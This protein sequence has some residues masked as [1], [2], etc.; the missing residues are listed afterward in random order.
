M[1][2]YIVKFQED[3]ISLARVAVSQWL[4]APPI[5]FTQA[6]LSIILWHNASLLNVRDFL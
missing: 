4:L 3:R 1:F 6:L 2:I 5:K